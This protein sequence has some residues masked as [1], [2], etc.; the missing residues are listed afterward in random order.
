MEMYGGRFDQAYGWYTNQTRLRL[1]VRDLDYLP[2]VC[3]TQIADKIDVL[4]QLDRAAGPRPSLAMGGERA[5][6]YRQLQNEFINL[7][8]AEFGFRKVGEGWISETMLA[9]TVRQLYPKDQILRHHRPE[10]L[11]GLELDVFLPG[12]ALAFEYQGQQHFHPIKAWGGEEALAELKQR[13][14]R[15][16]RICAEQGIMLIPIE[17]TDPLTHEF[18]TGEIRRASGRG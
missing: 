4:V 9:T 11:G 17:Y 3:P 10:W 12:R 7:T 14:R 15:K 16:A 1:G 2:E 5:K 13:D 6:L 18:V 8:R